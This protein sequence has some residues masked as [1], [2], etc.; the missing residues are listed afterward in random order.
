M[1]NKTRKWR[2]AIAMVLENAD[3]YLVSKMDPDLVRKSFLTP[4][5]SV[6][7]AYDAAV[8]KLGA[9]AS[10]IVMPYGGSTLPR[11]IHD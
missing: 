6:Q 3:I 9:E 7:A 8:A 4:F 11:C 2:S 5:E 1:S 10:V